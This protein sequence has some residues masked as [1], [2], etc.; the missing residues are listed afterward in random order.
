MSGDG[1]NINLKEATIKKNAER[2][3]ARRLK[4][5]RH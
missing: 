5:S 4:F 2:R 3:E 1:K